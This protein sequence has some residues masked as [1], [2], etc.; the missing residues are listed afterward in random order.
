MRCHLKNKC[1]KVDFT[2]QYQQIMS[3][4][5]SNRCDMI[6]LNIG[7][8]EQSILET[9][10]NIRNIDEYAKTPVLGLTVLPSGEFN[11]LARNLGLCGVIVK[12][13]DPNVVLKH[14]LYKQKH[15]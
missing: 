9:I 3:M 11:E 1:L 4:I 2:N 6:L 5:E 8:H 10:Q 15:H 14:S 7:V 13:F 12:P